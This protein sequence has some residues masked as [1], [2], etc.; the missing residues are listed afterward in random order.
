MTW[1]TFYLICFALGF[2]L[3]LLSVAGIFSHILFGNTAR[4]L[5]GY[6]RQSASVYTDVIAV[7]CH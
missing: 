3:T 5:S 7:L 1:E 2:S 4:A 6:F